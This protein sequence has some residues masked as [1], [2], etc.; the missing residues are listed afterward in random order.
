MSNPEVFVGVD[1]AKAWLDV[2]WL[3]GQSL[4]VDHTE[5]AIAGLVERLQSERP[6]LVVMEA[7]GGLETELASALMAVGVA[8]AVVNPRQ[9]R[10]YAKA[11]GRLAKTD[12]IDALVLAGFAAAIRPQ[13]RELPDEDTRALGDLL[14]RRRQLVEMRVQEKLRLQLA[15][16][17]QRASLREHIDWLNASIKRL[18]IELTHALRT[19]PAWR[20]K[21][22]LLEAIPGVGP[23]TRAT[24]LGELPELGS[25]SR[26]QIAALVG[27]APF[28]RDSG[29]RIGGRAIWGGRAQVRSVLYM[30]AVAAIRCNP[31]I[32]TF[33]KHLRAQGKP[34]KLAITA[35]MR[36]L[37]VTMNAMLKNGSAWSPTLDTQH[38]C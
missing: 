26:R 1:V 25:L 32:K 7:T 15:A 5:E 9:V 2:G 21:D 24:M 8:V 30:A 27:V 11:T 13:V 6:T 36:K 14:S 37:L 3:A 10:D 4:R 29:K 18:E 38:G 35:C 28:N 34:A 19:S 23:V 16:P 22:D 12:R 33:Y 20:D 17:V 31:V